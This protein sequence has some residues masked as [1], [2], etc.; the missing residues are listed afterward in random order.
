MMVRRMVVRCAQ[1]AIQ[2]S[3]FFTNSQSHTQVVAG[4]GGS[5]A[6]RCGNMADRVHST[7]A[8]RDGGRAEARTVLLLTA[9]IAVPVMKVLM[10]IDI[11]ESFVELDCAAVQQRK[12]ECRIRARRGL[13][14]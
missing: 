13:I 7:G 9:G 10:V 1:A 11:L 6:R 5:S 12:G 8:C 4:Q 14:L 2:I 3:A